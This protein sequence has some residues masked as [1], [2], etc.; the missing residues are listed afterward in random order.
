MVPPAMLTT[1]V[2]QAV[3]ALALFFY[4]TTPEGIFSHHGKAIVF[5]YY[6]VLVAGVIVGSATASASFWVARRLDGR[7]AIGMAL[8]CASTL[9]LIPV[10]GILVG[11]VMLKK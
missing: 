4:R 3:A 11:F 6:G 7:H 2:F 10:F 8:L 1:G 5:V 9:T